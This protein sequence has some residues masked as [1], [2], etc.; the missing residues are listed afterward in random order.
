[1]SPRLTYCA[2]YLNVSSPYL[3]PV[4]LE[5]LLA[6]LL[7]VLLEYLL[8]YLLPVLLEYLLAYLLPVSVEYVFTCT[9][10]SC[11]IFFNYN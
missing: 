4:L 9:Y 6:Y 10:Y 5:C 8:A 7:P 2:S 11:P 1:M 3:L